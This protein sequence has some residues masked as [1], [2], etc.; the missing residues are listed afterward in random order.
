MVEDF[1]MLNFRESLK[2]TLKLSKKGACR[3]GGIAISTDWVRINPC[4]N[5]C[6]DVTV[7]KVRWKTLVWF[8]KQKGQ[9]RNWVV[10]DAK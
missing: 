8:D 5:V 2:N 4:F 10:C 7:S 1:I 3:V 9:Q 6:F